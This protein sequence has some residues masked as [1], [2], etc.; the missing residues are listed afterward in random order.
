M[1]P[2]NIKVDHS[3][4]T[5]T[6]SLGIITDN[7]NEYYDNIQDKLLLLMYKILNISKKE[8]EL[9]PEE[10]LVQSYNKVN[11]AEDVINNFIVEDLVVICTNL[12]LDK[13]EEFIQK[14]S[15]K[16]LLKDA[17]IMPKDDLDDIINSSLN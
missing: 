1:T 7:H 13:A 8:Y 17:G 12:I 9:N 14:E 15:I 3:F 16:N 4:Q 2:I 10:K 5:L 11:L 6:E